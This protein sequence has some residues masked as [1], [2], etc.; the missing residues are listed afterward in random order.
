MQN[1]NYWLRQKKK[2]VVVISLG[3]G[4]IKIDDQNN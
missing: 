1:G 3:A 4:K 2:K